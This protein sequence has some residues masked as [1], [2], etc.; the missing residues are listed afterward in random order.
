MRTTT[1][2]VYNSATHELLATLDNA[3]DADIEAAISAASLRLHQPTT[4][5][6]RHDMLLALR[7]RMADNSS[8]FATLISQESGKTYND[9]LAEVHYANGYLTWFSQLALTLDSPFESSE[10]IELWREPVG[11]VGAITPWNFPCAM[12]VRKLAAAIAAGCPFVVKPSELTPLSALQVVE[13]TQLAGWD[14]GWLAVLVSDQ[15]AAVGHVLTSDTRVAKFTFTGSTRVGKLLNVQCA[16]SLKRVS[17]ELGGNAPLLVMADA[18]VEFAAQQCVLNKQRVS[19]QTCVAINRIYVAAAVEA[20]FVAALHAEV[21]RLRTGDPLDETT[22]VGHMIHLDAATKIHSMVE[23]AVA[24]GADVVLG[25]VHSAGSAFYPHTILRKVKHDD[26]LVCNEIF[27]PLYPIIKVSGDVD[28][29]IR[30]ANDTQAGLAAYV[31]SQNQD[32]L[33]QCKRRCNY[34]MIGLNSA[35][36][37]NPEAPFGG[38]KQSGFGREGGNVG[39]DDFTSVKYI[40]PA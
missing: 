10:G 25:G 38:I 30:L 31:F 36:I 28:E 33:N 29:M 26:D 21:H 15:S 32:T 27:G 35:I 4:G 12:I 6:E 9:A 23:Q 3:T 13:Y 8:T 39:L 20:E 7:E 24:Q 11:V 19:G 5:Q 34:G 16:A 40:K 22:E 37:S 17:M 14:E 18:D 2:D 1:F